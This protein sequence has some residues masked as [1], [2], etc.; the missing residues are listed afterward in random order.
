MEGAADTDTGD[1]GAGVSHHRVVVAVS[2]G[3]DEC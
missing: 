3:K 2:A 1:W